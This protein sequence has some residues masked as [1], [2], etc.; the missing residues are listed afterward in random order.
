MC[1]AVRQTSTVGRR[2]L[3]V[4]FHKH[5]VAFAKDGEHLF[6]PPHA[7]GARMRRNSS[8][9]FRISSKF[10]VTSPSVILCELACLACMKAVNSRELAGVCGPFYNTT[11]RSV[12]VASLFHTTINVS[13]QL[14]PIHGSH[15]DPRVT[16]LM[17]AF[18]A[19]IVSVIWGPQTLARMR[20]P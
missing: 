15:F 6:V 5:Q 16:G 11:R 4:A 7:V 13:W 17:T 3:R 19:A 14:F 2:R 12:F 1:P 10:I 18:L 9:P 8:V 20:M